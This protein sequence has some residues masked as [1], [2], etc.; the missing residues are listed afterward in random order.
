[1][2]PNQTVDLIGQYRSSQRKT[3]LV[4]Q[5]VSNA[6]NKFPNMVQLIVLFCF[7][8]L[9]N[10]CHF[11]LNKTVNKAKIFWKNKDRFI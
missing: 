4:E 1:M 2:K 6:W 5:F 3:I 7:C 8:F 11:I 9:D 10:P